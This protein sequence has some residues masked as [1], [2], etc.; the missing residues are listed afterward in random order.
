MTVDPACGMLIDEARAKDSATHGRQRYYF[1]SAECRAAFVRNPAG[2]LTDPPS[3]AM[4]PQRGCRPS[5]LREPE[6]RPEQCRPSEQAGAEKP[7]NRAQR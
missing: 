4:A 7:V 2:Y 1:C 5:T 6:G 3:V